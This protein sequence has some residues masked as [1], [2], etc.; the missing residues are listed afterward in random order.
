MRENKIRFPDRKLK[1]V[2][3]FLQKKTDLKELLKKLGVWLNEGIVGER[4]IR[5][6]LISEVSGL[7]YKTCSLF[8][9]VIGF[10][11]NLAILDSRNFNFM[12]EMLLIPENLKPNILQ[13]DKIYETLEDWENELSKK[14]NVNMPTLDDII[15]DYV[16]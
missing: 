12:K 2:S 6:V 4:R 7:G 1:F 15:C 10:C 16:G 14:L 11:R 8:L 13:N 9:M 3:E 5:N